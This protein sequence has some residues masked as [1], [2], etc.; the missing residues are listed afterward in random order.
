MFHHLLG[1]CVHIVGQPFL[2][3]LDDLE[4]RLRL[5]LGVLWAAYC[6]GAIAYKSKELKR[7]KLVIY[8]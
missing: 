4:C 2:Q 6:K 8:S 5:G 7:T 3:V 1:V